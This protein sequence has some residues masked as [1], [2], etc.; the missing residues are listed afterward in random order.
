M[1]SW[2]YPGFTVS[3]FFVAALLP[4]CR[5]EDDA[6]RN[7]K[8]EGTIEDINLNRSEL[9][10][11]FYHDRQK[12][13]MTVTGKINEDTEI[14]VNGKLVSLKELKKGQRVAGT[15]RV[16]KQN[17]KVVVIAEKVFVAQSETIRRETPTTGEAPA[18]G[19]AGSKPS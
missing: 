11:S 8:F 12:R 19:N 17:G 3:L 5:E 15:A 2:L 10:L 16:E 9:T 7:E 13:E 6:P 4:G 1:R 18:E 14:S